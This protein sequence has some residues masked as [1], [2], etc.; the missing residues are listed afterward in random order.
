MFVVKNIKTGKIVKE[1]KTN[2]LNRVKAMVEGPL[3]EMVVAQEWVR[4]GK[5]NHTALWEIAALDAKS[6]KEFDE[7]CEKMLPNLVI[8]EVAER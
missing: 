1:L 5:L 2:R 4:K 8:E 3:V 7:E 6:K